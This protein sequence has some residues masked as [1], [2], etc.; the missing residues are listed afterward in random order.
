METTTFD[1]AKFQRRLGEAIAW[2]RSK[3]PVSDPEHGLRTAA[4]APPAGLKTPTELAWRDA[5]RPWSAETMLEDARR[6]HRDIPQMLQNRQTIVDEV[7]SKRRALLNAAGSYPLQVPD[8]HLRGR[9]LLF[10]PEHNLEDGAAQ[11]AS[12]GFFEWDNVP[13]WDIWLASIVDGYEEFQIY[14]IAWVPPEFLEL[15]SDG[16]D[17]NPEKCIRWAEDVEADFVYQLRG[18]GLL[19]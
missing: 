11:A 9:F 15:A 18:A 14:L 19:R 12:R 7:A 8:G 1:L 4:L 13:P 5:P 17:V 6:R 2:Y 3:A 16:I 10:Y